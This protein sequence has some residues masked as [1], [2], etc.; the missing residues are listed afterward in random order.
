LPKG[1]SIDSSQAS[2]W[3]AQCTDYTKVVFADVNSGKCVATPIE[4]EIPVNMDSQTSPVPNGWINYIHEFTD[5]GW[6]DT[7]EAT[8]KISVQ[9]VFM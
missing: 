9:A 1:Y 5:F 2:A 4:L 7:V 6:G 3:Q 8:G